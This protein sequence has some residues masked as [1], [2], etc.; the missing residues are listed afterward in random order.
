MRRMTRRLLLLAALL[1][2]ATLHAQPGVDRPQ[3]KLREEPLVIVTRDGARHAFRVEMAVRPEDQ[4]IGMMFRTTMEPDEGMLFD[5]GVP[6][7]SAMWM[8]N[9]L[10]PLDMVFIA[11]D[12]RIHH[13]HERAVPQSLATIESRGPVRATLELQGGAAERLNLRVGDRVEHRVFGTTR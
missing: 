9:T 10:I 3:P 7:A 4:A 1:A 8:R 13:I 11:A 2:P 5:W 12:G 6:R